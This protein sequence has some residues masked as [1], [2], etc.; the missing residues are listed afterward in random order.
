MRR[1]STSRML[2]VIAAGILSLAVCTVI[3]VVVIQSA[4]WLLGE[5]I[6]GI[7]FVFCGVLAVRE[8]WKKRKVKYQEL[9]TEREMDWLEEL[10]DEHEQ[11]TRDNRERLERLLIDFEKGNQRSWLY[12]RRVENVRRIISDG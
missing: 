3:G 7:L 5:T 6:V 1:V 2:F 12:Q 9:A 8:W 10:A 11:G 4:K